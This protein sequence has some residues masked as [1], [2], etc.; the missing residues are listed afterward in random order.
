MPVHDLLITA[1]IAGLVKVNVSAAYRIWVCCGRKKKKK[2][3]Q[4]SLGIL[5]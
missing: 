4:V 5:V 3:I 1:A 2:L